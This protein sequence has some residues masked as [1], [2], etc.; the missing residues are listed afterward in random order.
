MDGQAEAQAMN[1]GAQ[2]AG[3]SHG[4]SIILIIFAQLVKLI[5]CTWHF[6]VDHNIC[7]LH[8]SHL[9]RLF[10]GH[11]FNIGLDLENALVE[12]LLAEAL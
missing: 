10:T 8:F 7:I 9:H 5:I 3:T 2:E 6:Q 1:E 4:L 12:V 11:R